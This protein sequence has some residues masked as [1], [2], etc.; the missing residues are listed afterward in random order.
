MLLSTYGDMLQRAGGRRREAGA[1]EHSLSE[2]SNKIRWKDTK[3]MKKIED[4]L[5]RC[6]A[7]KK[8]K[9]SSLALVIDD[10]IEKAFVLL[11]FNFG[12]FAIAV[13]LSSLTVRRVVT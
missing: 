8:M 7:N 5:K 2:S 10:W 13:S 1:Q 4:A 9:R 11:K 12:I 6:T 3:K